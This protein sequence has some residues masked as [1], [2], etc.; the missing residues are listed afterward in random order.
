MIEA[1]E[2]KL[3]KIVLRDYSIFLQTV[4]QLLFSF[5]RGFRVPGML[6]ALHLSWSFPPAPMPMVFPII[7]LL[8]PP[9]DA[10]SEENRA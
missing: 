10:F 8:P 5:Y 2:E 3:L 1:K 6:R 9:L 7:F 4:F